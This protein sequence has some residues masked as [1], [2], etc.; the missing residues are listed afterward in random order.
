MSLDMLSAEWGDRG[1]YFAEPIAP[2][3][4]AA[5]IPGVSEV[6][7]CQLQGATTSCNSN[8]S[9]NTT[10]NFQ[11]PPC[12]SDMLRV[13]TNPPTPHVVNERLG[14][15]RQTRSQPKLGAGAAPIIKR[16]RFSNKCTEHYEAIRLSEMRE[17]EGVCGTGKGVTDKGEVLRLALL[18]E[19]TGGT[20][21]ADAVVISSGS[22]RYLASM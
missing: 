1:E 9:R 17:G 4:A 11:T 5:N 10:L 20:A 15:A 19:A 6:K 18:G 2:A 14:S 3:P 22:F 16:Q 13:G 8:Q 7:T 21:A 12:S